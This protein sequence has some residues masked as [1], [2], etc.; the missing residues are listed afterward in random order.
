MV[1]RRA[2]F[3][4]ADELI[5]F[6]R[7]IEAATGGP[8]RLLTERLAALWLGLTAASDPSARGGRVKDGRGR[9]GR[10]RDGRARDGRTR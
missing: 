1:E 9:D 7:N 8:G 4:F 3:A 5:W 2:V 10:A 6:S